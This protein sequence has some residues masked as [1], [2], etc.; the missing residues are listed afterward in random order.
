MAK[1]KCS[2]CG[3]K[4]S[5]KASYTSIAIDAVLNKGV[6]TEDKTVEIIINGKK[7]K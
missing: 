4:Q 5:A 7:L 1:K 3:S 6:K 2:S